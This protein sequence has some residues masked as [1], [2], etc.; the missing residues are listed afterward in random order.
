MHF[1]NIP[2]Y[3]MDIGPMNVVPEQN[4]VAS[5]MMTSPSRPPCLLIPHEL[6]S[7]SLYNTNENGDHAATGLV[8]QGHQ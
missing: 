2:S 3:M 1:K 6:P 8:E 5:G 4:S 7:V